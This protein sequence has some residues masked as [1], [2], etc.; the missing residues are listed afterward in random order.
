MS[1]RR[2]RASRTVAG[3]GVLQSAWGQLVAA[4]K[5]KQVAPPA[6]QGERAEATLFHHDTKTVAE[7]PIRRRCLCRSRCRGGVTDRR[8]RRT[9]RSD[10]EASSGPVSPAARLR[11]QGAAGLR[12]VDAR[13]VVPDRHP[14]LVL[15]DG[16]LHLCRVVAV[17]GTPVHPDLLQPALE[18]RHLRAAVAPSQ[19]RPGHLL[20]GRRHRCR[21]GVLRRGG[22]RR[23]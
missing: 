2:A 15:G 14:P 7:T 10:A 17:V 23:R 4:V 9:R 22:G 3:M 12:P 1:S 20:G 18:L 19:R 13:R 16:L 11:L 21:A 5:K 6:G 8:P